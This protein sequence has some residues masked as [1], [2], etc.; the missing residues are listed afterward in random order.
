[1]NR[2]LFRTVQSPDQQW[3]EKHPERAQ[4][5]EPQWV[6]A[7]PK[8]AEHDGHQRG[9][10]EPEKAAD[11]GAR[12]ADKRLEAEDAVDANNDQVARN[13]APERPSEA[14]PEIGEV[15]HEWHCRKCNAFR[16]KGKGTRSVVRAWRAT[17][18]ARRHRTTLGG[19]EAPACL[20]RRTFRV[21][22][23]RKR[24]PAYDVRQALG[25]CARV[26][27]VSSPPSQKD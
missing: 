5:K 21:G 18:R 1:M 13:P 3:A 7:E 15:C 4:E 8:W 17:R 25:M 2:R 20:R 16:A 9:S 24:V 12:Q 27:P 22:A 26:E 14:A 10:G 11:H 19:S 23:Q 6:E